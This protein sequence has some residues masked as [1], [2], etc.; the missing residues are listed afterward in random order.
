MT[1]SP[2]AHC[3]WAQFALI[4]LVF[5]QSTG[6][7]DM[8]VNTHGGKETDFDRSGEQS[9]PIPEANVLLL[10]FL[11]GMVRSWLQFQMSFLQIP[12]S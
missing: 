10:Q 9:L 8:A 11:R 6:L 5:Y 12:G 2:T 1:Q 7:F 3:K 4:F